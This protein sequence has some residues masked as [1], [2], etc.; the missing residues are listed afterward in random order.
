[1]EKSQPGTMYR[2]MLV[3]LVLLSL[4]SVTTTARAERQM[5]T[6][7]QTQ[8]AIRINVVG[9]VPVDGTF[10][11]FAGWLDRDPAR[12]GVCQIQLRI[13]TTSLSTSI[14]TVRE[15]AI[16][17]GFLD[18]ARFPTIA[19]EGACEGNAIQGQL[20][21]H[22]VTRPFALTVDGSGPLSVA[23]GDLRRSE[24]GMEERRWLVGETIRITVTT[25]LLTAATIETKR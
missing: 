9:L 18:S 16:G 12:P 22:G 6:P 20:D 7:P 23:A 13:E 8:V 14:E 3:L 5:L 1:M 24:W 25:P 15:E 2:P 4:L 11:R 10:D 17:P 21:M 19:F